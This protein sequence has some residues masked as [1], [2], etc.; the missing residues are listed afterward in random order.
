MCRW[1][2][3]Q[4]DGPIW[5]DGWLDGILYC[6]QYVISKI[7]IKATWM[8][9]WLAGLLTQT[10]L[11]FHKTTESTWACSSSSLCYVVEIMKSLTAV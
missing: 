9:G 10:A 8:V 11:Y 7:L 6:I 4:T 2:D 3:G 5:M 1:M